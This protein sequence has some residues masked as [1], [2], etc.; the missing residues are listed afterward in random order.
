MWD[1]IRYTWLPRLFFLGTLSLALALILAVV[2]SP[3]VV[4]FYVPPHLLTL[5]A[6]DV[7]VRRT[8]LASAAGLIVTAFVF[9]RPSAA[10]QKKQ[11]PK[12]P[13]PG[14]MAGA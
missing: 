12:E 13:P 4:S 2:A 1:R 7:T 11:S 9:F 6:N 14:N 10:S 3:W 5:F 8:A